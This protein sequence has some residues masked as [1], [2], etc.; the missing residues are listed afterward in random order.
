MPE[1]VIVDGTRS[2]IGRAKKGSLKD[3]R[4]DDLAGYVVQKLMERLPEIDKATIN[5]LICGCGLP[6]GESG[7]NVARP[8][9]FLSGLPESVPGTQVNRFCASSLQSIRIAF[10]AIKAGEGDTF[11]S[12]GVESSTRVEPL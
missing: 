7:F 2:P 12:A 4:P 11:I 9:V 10:H 8:I 1:A 6:H 5:D 3:V